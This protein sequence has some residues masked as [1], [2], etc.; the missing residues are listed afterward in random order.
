MWAF[1]LSFYQRMAAK[2]MFAKWSPIYEREVIEN[3][4]SAPGR[5]ATA[6]TRLLALKR[7][8]GIKPLIADIGIGTGLLAQQMFDSLPCRIAGLDFSEDMMAACVGREV[9]ELLLKCD[10]GKD[11]WPLENSGFDCVVSAGLAEYLT[12]KMLQHYI[13]ESARILQQKGYLIFT[14]LP[15]EG[16]ENKASVWHGHSGT[17]LTCGYAPDFIEAQLKLNGFEL[18]GHSTRFKG[19]LFTDGSSYDYR[20]I[21]AQKS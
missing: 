21:T 3:A 13:K 15:T 18:L 8:E 6:A 11:H 16:L 12:E 10:V 9:T 14:Y 7:F 5:V 20:L 17:Y 2:R 1:F 4:Y 19:C